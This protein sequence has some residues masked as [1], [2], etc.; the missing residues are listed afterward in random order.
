MQAT[1]AETSSAESQGEPEPLALLDAVE[2]GLLALGV[3]GEITFVNRTAAAW[4]GYAPEELWGR[5][6]ACVADRPLTASAGPGWRD[7]CFQRRNGTELDVEYRARQVE[8][9]ALV[10]TFRDVTDRKHSE[11]VAE[12]QTSALMSTLRGL[13]RSPSV[14][15]YLGEVLKALA[16]QLGETSAAL[17]LLDEATGQLRLHLDCM[18]GVVKSGAETD[19]P[20]AAEEPLGGRVMAK[21]MTGAAAAYDVENSPEIELYRPFCRSRGVKGLL[22][23][24]MRFDGKVVGTFSIRSTQRSRFSPAEIELA[25]VLA[26]QATLALQLTRLADEAEHTAIARERERA[27]E[28]RAAE[29]ERSYEALEGEIAERR[30]AEL[31]LRSNEEVLRGTLAILAAEPPLDTF[32]GHVLKAVTQQLSGSASTLWFYD[33]AENAFAI[34]MSY[35]EGRIYTGEAV[36]HRT[37]GPTRLDGDRPDL[38][39]LRLT[40][41]RVV[42]NDVQNSV[43]LEPQRTWLQSQ[44]VR[45]VLRLPL[46]AGDTVLGM[47]AVHHKERAFWYEGEAELAQ[48]LAGQ[49]SL[50]VQLT[51]L[52]EQARRAAV[53]EERNRFAQEIHDTLAQGFT[54]IHIQLEAAQH[55]LENGA[56]EAAGRHMETAGELARE[57]LAEAR[58]SVHALRPLALEEVSLPDALG[59]MIRRLGGP[60][61]MEI[62]F[63]TAGT[64]RHLPEEV[65]DNLLRMCQEALANALRHAAATEVR[66]RLEYHCKSVRVTV[67]DNG[68]G[69]NV[70]RA[71]AAGRGLGLRGLRERAARI[72]GRLEL[73]S[74][75]GEGTTVDLC[76]EDRQ[77]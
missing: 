36:T 59:R 31:A 32:L 17:W 6:P 38:K 5:E 9:G 42:V 60:S 72:G 3:R 61:G 44:G 37:H 16:A 45:A 67:T 13:E 12:A 43:A 18:D 39:E 76:V 20:G 15:A 56:P 63:A 19:H 2:V 30:R 23:V 55:A 22:V 77:R 26:H 1:Q 10:V 47:I 33:A 34:H 29:L 73:R 46:V 21:T 49:A 62:S 35:G 66:V 64:P 57:S 52:A 75:P 53:V 8:S 25:E 28:E 11:R 27:A 65:E 51:R 24:P 58:R 54:G 40:R 68:P 48:A 69:F 50:A 70:E 7:A 14:H 41:R 71:L 74:R 4:L